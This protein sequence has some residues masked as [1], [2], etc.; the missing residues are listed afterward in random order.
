MEEQNQFP[1]V[2]AQTQGVVQ[3]PSPGGADP[4]QVLGYLQP[5][6]TQ[7]LK[8]DHLPS[9]VGYSTADLVGQSGLEEQYNSALTG[10][11]GTNKVSVNAAGVRDRDRGRRV[12]AKSGDDLVTSINSRDPGRN[13]YSRPERRP[14]TR[15]G[16]PA[17]MPTRVR[18]WS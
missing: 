5:A 15:R 6:T 14:S 10:K 4:A 12:L 3:Y 2:T 13:P 11:M 7:E 1:G 8:A 17:T 16:L 18:P 9:A